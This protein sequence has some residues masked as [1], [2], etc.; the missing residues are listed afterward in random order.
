MTV[1]TLGVVATVVLVGSLAAAQTPGSGSRDIMPELLAEVRGLRA[2]IEQMTASS[3]RVQLALGR[4][5][6]QEQ[7]LTVANS[8][9]ADVRNQLGNAQRGAAELQERATTLESMVSGQ[10]EM[11]KPEGQSTAEQIRRQITAELQMVQRQMIA[12]NAEVQRLTAQENTLANEVSTEEA[13]WG[14]LNRQLEDLE[15]SLRSVK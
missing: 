12:A 5:Q 13:R 8:R 10:S 2:A 9:L 6:L 4:L 11:P 7:R 14:D 15:R 3:S 1:R